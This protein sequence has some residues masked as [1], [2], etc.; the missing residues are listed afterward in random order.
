M[1]Q[2]LVLGIIRFVPK[3]EAPSFYTEGFNL[4]KKNWRGGFSC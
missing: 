1:L 4:R 3:E 2:S